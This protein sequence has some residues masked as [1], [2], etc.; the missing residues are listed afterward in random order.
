MDPSDGALNFVLKHP[1]N[2]VLDTLA[3]KAFSPK[4]LRI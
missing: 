3:G 1:H 4:H 2:E